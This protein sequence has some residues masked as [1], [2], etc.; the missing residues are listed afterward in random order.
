M[1]TKYTHPHPIETSNL[2]M[3]SQTETWS[4]G[5]FFHVSSFIHTQ[6]TRPISCHCTHVS[7]LAPHFLKLPFMYIATFQK[8]GFGRK[9]C[10]KKITY[11]NKHKTQCF[12]YSVI[13][14][15]NINWR[16][17]KTKL[18]LKL[19]NIYRI[20]VFW[21]DSPQYLQWLQRIDIRS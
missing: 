5:F 6:K 15:L 20:K 18:A 3:P 14:C 21:G 13:L 8:T 10:Y 7:N 2:Q 11:S 19:M 12:I 1:E 16:L 9:C 17:F 4:V